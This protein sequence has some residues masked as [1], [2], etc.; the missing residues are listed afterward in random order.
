MVQKLWEYRNH[1]ATRYI[2]AGLSA[3]ITQYAVLNLSFYLLSMNIHVA[4]TLGFVC[5]LVV[6]YLFNRHWVF[7]EAG[8]QKHVVRQ[9]VEYTALVIFNY[10]FT[11]IGISFLKNQ[12]IPP[13]ISPFII[14][15]LI[16][17]W[18]YLLFR[19]VIFKGKKDVE[20]SPY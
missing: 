17:C 14:T 18:N 13:F 16:T 7:G 11:L 1:S 8:R 10:F 12:G 4:T 3:F 9:T 19:F 6:S 2:V 5:G 15:G 20:P